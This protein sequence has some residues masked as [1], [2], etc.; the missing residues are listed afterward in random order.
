[1]L[2]YYCV[3]EIWK[4]ILKYLCGHHVNVL[5]NVNLT[6]FPVYVCV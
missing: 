6:D 4:L 3:Q 5:S 2:L 1:M